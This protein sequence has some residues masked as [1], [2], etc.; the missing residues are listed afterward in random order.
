MTFAAGR[1]SWQYTAGLFLLFRLGTFPDPANP[2]RVQQKLIFLAQVVG[3]EDCSEGIR[4]IRIACD[5]PSFMTQYTIAMSTAR[6][7]RTVVLIPLF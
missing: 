6:A 7:D 2:Q 1:L 4:C 5:A 3:I